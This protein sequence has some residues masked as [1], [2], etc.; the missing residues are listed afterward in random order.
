MLDYKDTLPN[1]V[2]EEAE[3]VAL[4]TL[5]QEILTVHMVVVPYMVLVAGLDKE[6]IAVLLVDK[7]DNGEHMV[8]EVI[9][10]HRVVVVQM[11]PVETTAAVMVALL[12]A[13]QATAETVEFLAG[14]EAV[15]M[16]LVDKETVDEEKYEYGLG[17]TK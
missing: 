4:A 1:M 9:L 15:V 14:E 13:T 6:D 7:V 12:L 10:R 5:V 11:E 16:Q 2:V 3:G 17:R 8:Q